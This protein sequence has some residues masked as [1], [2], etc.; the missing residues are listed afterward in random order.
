M[1]GISSQNNNNEIVANEINDNETK[2]NNNNNNSH[3]NNNNKAPA[4]KKEKIQIVSKN[5]QQKSSNLEKKVLE[6]I[7]KNNPN[8][9]D[10]DMIYS[11]ISKHFFMQTLSDQAK[12][13]I[14]ITM[15]LH[16]VKKNLTLFKQGDTGTYWYI[17][18]EGT[19]SLYINNE[20]KKNLI[21]G[22]S[23]GEL[24]LMNDAPRS[25]TVK[26]ETDCEVW[27]LKREVFRKIL[28]FISN[29]NYSQNMKFLNGI[30]IP[31]DKNI[32]SLLANN[33]LQEIYKKNNVIFTEGEYG[34]NMYIIKE[35]EVCCKKN[36]KFIRI[37]KEGENFGQK[38]IL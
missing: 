21:K 4:R 34:N 24:A 38:A 22:D 19:F 29:I 5:K 33:L 11:I 7:H 32:K 20:F 2:N 17:V 18:H 15:S 12:N 10:Y 35:G 8:K 9:E 1:G 14:I 27:T 6:L 30:D 25:A 36:G 37:L 23:F 28:E 3:N 16:R 31:L 26:A 13:E